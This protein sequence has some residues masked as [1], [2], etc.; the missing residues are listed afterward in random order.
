MGSGLAEYEECCHASGCN[1]T[2]DECQLT[3]HHLTRKEEPWP[4]LGQRAP[5][6]S[7]HSSL[8]NPTFDCYSDYFSRL[9]QP[10][11][12]VPGAAAERVVERAVR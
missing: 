8:Y 1:A 5:K 12:R 10:R 11:R 9:Q 3:H 4:R 7:S 2:D 6:Y